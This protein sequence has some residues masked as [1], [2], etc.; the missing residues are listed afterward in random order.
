MIKDINNFISKITRQ[1]NL[2]SYIFQ[3]WTDYIITQFTYITKK[4]PITIP[5]YNLNNIKKSLSHI[6]QHITITPTDKMKNNFRFTCSLYTK[7][8]IAQ[9]VTNEPVLLS[10]P[11]I[12]KEAEIKPQPTKNAYKPTNKTISQIIN[13]HNNFL[14]KYQL[15]TPSTKL[16]FLYVIHKAHKFGNRPVTA[17]L[18]VTT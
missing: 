10:N 13:E 14:A 2:P 18:N 15:T 4:L 5:E 16:P 11:F 9:K 17:A 6:H 3:E 1:F 7:R 8:I 12:I